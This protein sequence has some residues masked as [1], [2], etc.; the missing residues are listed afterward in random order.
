MFAARNMLLTRPA[1]VA[2]G[3]SDNF[4]RADS[5]SSPGPQ[6]TNQNGVM[7]I[8]TNTAYPVSTGIWV[9]AS[10]NTPLAG[11]NASVTITLGSLVSSGSDYAEIVL[12]ANSSGAGPVLILLGAALAIYTQTGWGLAG[13]TAR[14]SNSYTWTTGDVIEFRRVGTVYTSYKNGVSTPTSWTDAGGAVTI[15]AS[16]RIVGIG[17]NSSGT[18][19]RQ[20]DA[21]SAT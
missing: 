6:W 18:S 15:G 21:F 5:T 19:Y 9:Q 10:N 14:V 2:S 3:L 17:G 4:N 1:T 11:D 7:G 16:N 12:G 13:A 20:I 8:D